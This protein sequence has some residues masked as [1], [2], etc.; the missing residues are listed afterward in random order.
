MNSPH[1]INKIVNADWKYVAFQPIWVLRV[2]YETSRHTHSMIGVICKTKKWIKVVKSHIHSAYTSFAH[3]YIIRSQVL[4]IFNY[5]NQKG[6]FTYHIRNHKTSTIRKSKKGF[7]PHFSYLKSDIDNTHKISF[8]SYIQ[9]FFFFVHPLFFSAQNHFSF[10][11]PQWGKNEILQLKNKNSFFI[12]RKSLFVCYP[13]HQK[14]AFFD[15]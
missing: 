14:L 7:L 10:N 1:T 8:Y 5:C 12:C 2:L 11:Y 15:N 4:F 3:V 13:Q 6:L 9:E